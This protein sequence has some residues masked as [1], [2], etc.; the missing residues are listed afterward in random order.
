MKFYVKLSW[1]P[2]FSPVQ[3]AELIREATG[4]GAATRAEYLGNTGKDYTERICLQLWDSPQV[5]WDGKVL[6]CCRNFW[7]EF[8]GNAFRDGLT[9]SL[10]SEKMTYARAMLT[11]TA[12][13]RGDIPCASCDIY[14]TRQ[15]TRNWIAREDAIAHEKRPAMAEEF[16]N[17]AVALA[18]AGKRAEAIERARMVLQLRPD[19]AQALEVLGE[20]ARLRGRAEAAEHYLNKAQTVRQRKKGPSLKEPA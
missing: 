6:G 19:H 9:E 18:R 10:N 15:R 11:G 5:N 14:L 13:P 1:D 8:G 17:E 20:V 12:A 4:S 2:D 3:N 7:G 16:W